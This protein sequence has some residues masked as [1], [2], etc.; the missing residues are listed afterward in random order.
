VPDASTRARRGKSGEAHARAWL[1]ARGYQWVASNWHC[2]SG[3]LDLVMIDGRELVFIEVK[4]RTG[5]RAGRASEAIS[6]DKRRKILT[7]AEWFIA[8]HPPC[9]DM[10]W[11]CDIVAVTIEP[12]SG[13][14]R[15]EH[16]VNA[17]I[18]G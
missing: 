7:S 16:F 5:E 15:V 10:I 6:R 12:H 8:T 11:R 4:T 14:A 13:E 17:L 2:Q 1:E 3:E 9:H 18:V